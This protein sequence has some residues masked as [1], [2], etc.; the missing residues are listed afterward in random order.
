MNYSDEELASA[1]LE[2]RRRQIIMYCK[3][4][5]KAE[6]LTTEALEFISKNTTVLYDEVTL[7]FSKLST[8][9]LLHIKDNN[10]LP[11]DEL[12]TDKWRTIISPE[13]DNL[14]NGQ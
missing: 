4:A 10:C 3:G 14:I 5:I 7:D 9:Q 13:L 12:R 2:H 11:G 6:D 1:V 8:D